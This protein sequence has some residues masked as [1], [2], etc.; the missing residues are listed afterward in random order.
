MSEAALASRVRPWRLKWLAGLAATA[1]SM[2]ACGGGAAPSGSSQLMIGYI[3]KTLSNP[4]F[5]AMQAAA[6]KEAKAKNINLVFEAGK[7]DGDNATQV[8]EVEDLATRGA[9]VIIVVPNLSSGIVPALQKA[10]AQGAKIIA[11]DTDV[12]PASAADSFVATDNLKAGVLN[13]QWAKA[14]LN[15][16][17]PVFALL[18]GTPGS[19]VN[20]DRM[21]GFLQGYGLQKSQAASDLITNGDQGTAQTAMENALTKNPNINLVWTINEPAGLGAAKAIADRGLAGKIRVVSMDGGCRGIQGVQNGQLS[22]DVMQFPAKMAQ[23]SIDEAIDAAN[24]K[25]IP[26]RVDTGEVLVTKDPQPGV[27][28]QPV[29][30]GMANCWGSAG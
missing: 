24:G 23:I 17:P 4:Y 9:K 26:Q 14:V 18:E 19:E 15:G 12:S 30:F 8:S 21:N 3:V 6:Q 20:T 11:V 1:L 5:A 10:K 27:P 7:Y 25:S 16:K 28:S 29:S 2:A 13:G 22:T